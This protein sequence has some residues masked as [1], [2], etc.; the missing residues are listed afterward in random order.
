MF[1]ELQVKQLQAKF[2]GALIKSRKQGGANV[3]YMEGYAAIEA[4]NRIFGFGNWA[5]NIIELVMVEQTPV[6][7]DSKEGVRVAYTCRYRVTIYGNDRAQSVNFDDI[8]FGNATSYQS[9]GD[10]I[11]SASKEAVTDAMKRA[12]RNF[13]NQFGLALYDKEKRNVDYGEFDST[14]LVERISQLPAATTADMLVAMR[15]TDKDTLIALGKEIKDRT[16]KK[17]AA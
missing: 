5:G 7:K 2:D 11:E 6:S 4:A 10:A 8:G 14:P 13:G 15:L 1:T 9:L 12:L 3:S 16:E 17:E